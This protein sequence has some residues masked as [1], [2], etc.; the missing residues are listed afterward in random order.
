MDAFK[1]HLYKLG[2][3]DCF[4]AF[5]LIEKIRYKYKKIWKKIELCIGWILKALENNFD[6]YWLSVFS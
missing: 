4:N 6:K 3:W 5:K 1:K 2:I